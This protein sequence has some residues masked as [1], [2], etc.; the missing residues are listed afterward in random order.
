MGA[1]VDT[2]DINNGVLFQIGDLVS[3]TGQGVFS[4]MPNQ[5]LGPVHFITAGDPSSLAFGNSVFGYFTS[6][7]I[8]EPDGRPCVIP[9][10]TSRDVNTNLV[11]P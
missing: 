6:T 7:S 1:T 5:F 11:Y 3:L 9:P 4:G 8:T 2:G 10:C